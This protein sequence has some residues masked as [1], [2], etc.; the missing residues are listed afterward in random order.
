MNESTPILFLMKGMVGDITLEPLGVP[1]LHLRSQERPPKSGSV[2]IDDQ[3]LKKSFQHIYNKKCY[4]SKCS[5]F[6]RQI[7]LIGQNH[8]WMS[9]WGSGKSSM[10]Q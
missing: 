1:E 6:V 3:I 9:S 8:L 5:Y 4:I 2:L 7:Q 10:H